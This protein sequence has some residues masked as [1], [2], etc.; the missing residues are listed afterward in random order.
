MTPVTILMVVAAAL[1]HAGWNL[2]AKRSAPVGPAFILI[3]TLVSCVAYAPWAIWLLVH[4]KISWSAPVIA[5]V[6]V[7][8]AVHLAYN[9]CLQRGYQV[10]D[11]SVVYPIARGTGPTLATLGAFL[12]LRETPTTSGVLGMV[13][14]VSGILLIAT[15]GS[16]AAFRRPSGQ[17][18]LR[19][20]TAT[21][22]LIACYT[23]ADAFAVKALGITP[24]VLDWIT[25]IMRLLLLAPVMLRNPRQ[26]MVAM[27]GHWWLATAV[28]VLSPLSYILV[29]AA[30][31]R[32]APL[33]IVAPMR[34]MSM[35]LG[36]LM[37]MVV[38]KEAVGRGRLVGCAVLIGGV[39][40]LSA[41]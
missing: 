19:W 22:G 21:G 14:V 18:G 40:L 15:Q 13:L 38:L 17:A 32:G 35:M 11:L 30:L 23:V 16:L 8:G 34:E 24:V 41:S 3:Y 10:A 39:V 2:I 27:R 1:I 5:I 33:S 37:G 4:G 7:S 6:V 29:L 25:N 26:V 9:L 12:I 28:G 20:G 31:S 36:A